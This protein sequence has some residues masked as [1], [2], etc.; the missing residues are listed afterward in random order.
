MF[1]V[2]DL[3]I[4]IICNCFPS[5]MPINVY[6]Y[7]LFSQLEAITATAATPLRTYDLDLVQDV[8]DFKLF[9][10]ARDE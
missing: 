6:A 5:F 7:F 4:C 2:D 3:V 9:L 8:K 1:P 10:S